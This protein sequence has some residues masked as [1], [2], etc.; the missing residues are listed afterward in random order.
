MQAPLPCRGDTRVVFANVGYRHSSAALARL[1]LP[2]PHCASQACRYHSIAAGGRCCWHTP[3]RLCLRERFTLTMPCS[4]CCTG[5]PLVPHQRQRGVQF[6]ELHV[7]V[8]P[9]MLAHRRVE[10]ASCHTDTRSLGPG[11]GAAVG[12]TSQ[13]AVPTATLRGCEPPISTARNLAVRAD[14]PHTH[15]SVMTASPIASLK[16]HTAFLHGHAGLPQLIIAPTSYAATH[17]C[18]ESV[19]HDMTQPCTTFRVAPCLYGAYR[20][21]RLWRTLTSGRRSSC[22]IRTACYRLRSGR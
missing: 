15:P 17:G 22:G 5:S 2:T 10:A 4:Q 21:I 20:S 3:L 13:L 6:R 11:I 1:F 9:A 7:V 14:R 16:T 12:I 18:R 8:C 19:A